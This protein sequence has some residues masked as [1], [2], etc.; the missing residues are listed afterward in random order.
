MQILEKFCR[1]AQIKWQNTDSRRQ[2]IKVFHKRLLVMMLHSSSKQKTDWSLVRSSQ[3]YRLYHKISL[4]RIKRQVQTIAFPTLKDS[5]N[6]CFSLL[7]ASLQRRNDSS[8][9]QQQVSI[10][11]VHPALPYAWETRVLLH[12]QSLLEHCLSRS[13]RSRQRFWAASEHTFLRRLITDLGSALFII[14][15]PDTIM[16]APAWKTLNTHSITWHRS[17]S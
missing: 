14:A 15:L 5:Q 12:A 11:N 8:V 16:F 9:Q 10:I 4:H 7:L 2:L 13:H 1:N 17:T 6:V 3:R